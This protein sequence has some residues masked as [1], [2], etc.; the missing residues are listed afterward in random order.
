[1]LLLAFPAKKVY[2]PISAVK[3]LVKPTTRKVAIV[4][5]TF[6]KV[7]YQSSLKKVMPSSSA[8]SVIEGLILF[9]APKYISTCVPNPIK[10]EKA[11]ITA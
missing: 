5:N 1:M 8:A 2:T 9:I 6:G 3:K 11:K 7:I 10:R 4:E